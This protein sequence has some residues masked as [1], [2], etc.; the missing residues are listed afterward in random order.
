MALEALASSAQFLSNFT[1]YDSTPTEDCSHGSTTNTNLHFDNSNSLNFDG[2]LDQSS[3]VVAGDSAAKSTLQGRKK[4]KRRTKI[5]KNKEEAEAQRMT[6]I[7]VERNR[8]KQMNDHLAVLRSLMPEAYI[9]R[10]DQAS[11]VGGAIDF[12]KELE[13]L[14]Q[15]LEAK[16]GML[17]KGR[18]EK[19]GANHRQY[20]Y[21]QAMADIEVTMIESHANL[22][23]LSKTRPRQLMKM[24]AGFQALHLAILHLNITTLDPFVLYT[25]SAKVEEGCHLSSADDIANAVH[26]MFTIIEEEEEAAL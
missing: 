12:V 14:L 4:R 18:G 2:N 13:Q 19:R 17:E 6:H 8:R 20:C 5:C 21:R 3:S 15:S 25:I 24:V 23:I 7:I 16:K 11:I 1:I 10:S 22:R 26:H 9:Q